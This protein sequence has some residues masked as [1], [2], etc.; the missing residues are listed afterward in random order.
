MKARQVRTKGSMA[1][2]VSIA[3]I[4]KEVKEDDKEISEESE[5]NG[6]GDTGEVKVKVDDGRSEAENKG[7]FENVG[8]GGGGDF[9]D[10]LLKS[11]AFLFEENLLFGKGL[12]DGV[13]C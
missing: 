13:R 11:A 4:D 3:L 12:H 7:V 5:R 8:G 10:A 9:E 1:A 2:R 6:S